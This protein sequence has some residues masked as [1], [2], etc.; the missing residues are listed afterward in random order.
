MSNKRRHVRVYAYGLS[1]ET[2]AFPPA[3]QQKYSL[4]SRCQQ[5]HHTSATSAW[6]RAHGNTVST[7]NP[8]SEGL[9]YALVQNH[10]SVMNSELK[11]LWIVKSQT[12]RSQFSLTR[13]LLGFWWTAVN[14]GNY[15]MER[16]G[17]SQDHD[18][19]RPPSAHIWDRAICEKVGTRDYSS[20]HTHEYL[21]Q[22]VL[23]ELLFQRP[24][25]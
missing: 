25:G 14:G 5:Q 18:G 16:K 22:E 2:R 7:R 21:I 8:S 17:N 24:R 10:R 13:M 19:L 15:G 23:N 4:C 12:F 11:V 20:S 1:P 6:F 9:E 3:S